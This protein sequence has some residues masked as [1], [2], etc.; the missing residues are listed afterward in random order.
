A[1]AALG[2]IVGA[3]VCYALVLPPVFDRWMAL[4]RWMRIGISVA[5]L[6]PL[7]FF[8][9][10]RPISAKRVAPGFSRLLSWLPRQ[11]SWLPPSGGRSVESGFSRTRDPE[12]GF[13]RTQDPESGFSRTPRWRTL[14][15]AGLAYFACLGVGFMLIEIGLM[16]RF[17]IFLGHPVYSLTVILFT[18]L[19]GGGLGSALSR[20][21]VTQRRHAAAALGAIVVSVV[22]Y[23][24]VLPPVFDRW[25]AL[26]RWMR[27]GISVACLLPLGLLLGVPLPAG[28]R[29]LAAERPSAI[30]WAWAINGVTSV[31]GATLAIFVAMHWGF[32]RVAFAGATA[33][34]IAMLL[35]AL[36][37]RSA[38]VPDAV[39]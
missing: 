16:Q 5:C 30:A 39:V 35:A 25:M 19:L 20:G 14:P 38:T 33:Y 22:C 10:E 37:K 17:V 7:A 3:V 23:A 32:T 4:E 9:P 13:S 18:L 6:L 21:W 2:A 36:M 24:L 29:M 27:I 12:W 15:A 11:L 28:V 26:E 1:A 31:L 34:G 8:S